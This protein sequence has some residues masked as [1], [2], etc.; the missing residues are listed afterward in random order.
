MGAEISYA[1]PYTALRN[2]THKS[3][4]SY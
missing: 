3:L 2:T 1:T 4:D